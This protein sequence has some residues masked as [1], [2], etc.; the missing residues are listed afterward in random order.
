VAAA[1]AGGA[2]RN[3]GGGG[4]EAL[5]AAAWWMLGST[6]GTVIGVTAYLFATLARKPKRPGG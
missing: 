1:R 6:W 3:R 2:G 4:E 5:S